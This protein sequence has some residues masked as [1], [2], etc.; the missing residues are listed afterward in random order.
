MWGSASDNVK[1]HDYPYWSAPLR[2]TEAGR[3]M[4]LEWTGRIGLD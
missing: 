4:P 1:G 3:I 2:F